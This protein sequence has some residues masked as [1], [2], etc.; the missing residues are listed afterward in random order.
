[1]PLLS[2][3]LRVKMS[4]DDPKLKEKVNALR[5]VLSKNPGSLPVFL[6]LAYPD[7]RVVGIDLGQGFRVAVTLAFL[8]ELDKTFAPSDVTFGLADRM[9]L[10]E[11][12]PPPWA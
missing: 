10:E 6:D 5:A 12:E 8:S 2:G 11:R 4:A 9:T 3:G 7:R 1:M